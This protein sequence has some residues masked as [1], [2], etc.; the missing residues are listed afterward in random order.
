MKRVLGNPLIW[1]F[2]LL[3]VL[4]FGMTSLGGVFHWLFT[5][6]SRPVY[7]QESFAA[8]VEAHLLLVGVSSLIAVIIGVTA[9]VG[10]TRPAG[11][12]FRSLVETLVAR[13]QTFPP[14]A[15]LVRAVEVMGFSERR[16]RGEGF[17][18]W[19]ANGKQ[20]ENVGE[21]LMKVGG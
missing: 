19:T 12:E 18:E 9:G 20:K 3:L 6:L 2:A 5:E 10:V 15:V 17:F 16:Q 1:L 14:V 7:Q 4:I 11:K 21:R 13:G 8:L